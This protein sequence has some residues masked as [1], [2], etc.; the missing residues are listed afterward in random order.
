VNDNEYIATRHIYKWSVEQRGDETTLWID[1]A[2]RHN[3]KVALHNPEDAD[4]WVDDL[5]THVEY[6]NLSSIGDVEWLGTQQ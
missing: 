2:G 5:F 4:I 3:F 1:H 6:V